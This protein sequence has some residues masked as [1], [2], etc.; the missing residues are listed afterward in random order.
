MKMMKKS[1]PFSILPT[2]LILLLTG[3]AVSW[4]ATS[5]IAPQIAQAYT[6]RIDLTLNR[7]PNETYHSFLRRAETIAR[8]ATQRSFDRDILVTEAAVTIVCDNQGAI[9]PVLSLVVS[10]QA[11]KNRPD[12]QKWIT[13]F[14]NAES[15][16]RFKEPEKTDSNQQSPQTPVSNPPPT[17]SSPNPS[18]DPNWTGPVN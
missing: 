18:L 10:R 9:A 2:T 17:N 15:L 11:W 3:T 1:Q 14:P 4:I 16:L 6:A 12:P 13:Y 7:E 5:A 8:A